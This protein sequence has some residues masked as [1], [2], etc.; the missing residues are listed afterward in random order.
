MRRFIMLSLFKVNKWG[1]HCFKY[2]SILEVYATATMSSFFTTTWNTNC[3]FLVF[4]YENSCLYLYY[5]ATRNR[6]TS[7]HTYFKFRIVPELI[8]MTTKRLPR[9]IFEWVRLIKL[10]FPKCVL[11]TKFKCSF[12]N[13]HFPK[14]GTL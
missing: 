11:G 4:V 7:R 1:V 12:Q 14:F 2:S 10:T 8:D 5:T 9:Y 3:L 13:A 6:I